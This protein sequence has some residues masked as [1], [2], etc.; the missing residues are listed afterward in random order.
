[1][2]VGSIYGLQ[3]A[4]YVKNLLLIGFEI[5]SQQVGYLKSHMTYPFGRGAMQSVIK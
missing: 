2:F 5:F 1:M 3:Q 4:G